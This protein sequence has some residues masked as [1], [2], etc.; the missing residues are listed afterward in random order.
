MTVTDQLKILDNKI[1]ANQAQYD[2]DRLAA[3]I[4]ALLSGELGKYEYL[5]SEDLGYK[6]TVVK[7]AKFE[8]P[9]L[10]KVSNKELVEEDKKEGLLKRLK[11]IE[12]KNEEH[13]KA[14]KDKTD[15]K[16]KIDLFNEDLSSEPVP[17]LKEIKDIG[18]NLDYVKL[19]FTGGNKK[20]YSL[21]NFKTLEKLI[22]DI[23]NGDLSIGEAEIK[24]NEF[25]E[26]LDE[27]RAY[28]A[29]ESKYIDLKKVLPKM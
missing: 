23:Y 21:K 28:S 1:K 19:F 13:L 3:K 12:T 4:S 17:L 20:A 5:T 27:L 16:S 29:R 8:Y 15:I 7:Q 26:R 6:P 10:G 2:V 18:D 9:P 24:R 14:I 11:N 25:A 22:K